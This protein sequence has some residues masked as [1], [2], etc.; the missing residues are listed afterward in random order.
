MHGC[1]CCS[2]CFY[3]KFQNDYTYAT[4]YANVIYN[5]DRHTFFEFEQ[6]SIVTSVY[7]YIIHILNIFKILG[8]KHFC[9]TIVCL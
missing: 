9:E 6:K 5:T 8:G 7:S 2:L 4:R 3:F 1:S